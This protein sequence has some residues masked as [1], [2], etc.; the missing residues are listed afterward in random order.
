MFR[1]LYSALG[2]EE[3]VTDE[4]AMMHPDEAEE[5]S[6]EDLLNLLSRLARLHDEGTTDNDPNVILP[7]ITEDM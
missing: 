3:E 5:A 7:E 4:L 1:D 2:L 6:V